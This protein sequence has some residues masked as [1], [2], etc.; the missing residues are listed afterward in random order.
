MSVA[1]FFRKS[2]MGCILNY[3]RIIIKYYYYREISCIQGDSDISL[4]KNPVIG[5]DKKSLRKNFSYKSFFVF[6][7]QI[8]ENLVKIASTLVSKMDYSLEFELLGK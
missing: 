3:A 1:S 7:I 4:E 6:E 5:D 8:I 2:S